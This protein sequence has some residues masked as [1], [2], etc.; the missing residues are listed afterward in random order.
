LAMWFHRVYEATQS[1]RGYIMRS[2][3]IL[4]HFMK[5]SV[6][7]KRIL[8]AHLEV[9]GRCN[10][11]CSFCLRPPKAIPASE[12]TIGE[13]E[14]ILG[15]LRALRCLNLSLTG[16]EPL[17]RTDFEDIACSSIRHGFAVSVSTNAHLL[18]E[19]RVR[20]WASSLPFE[21]I[22]ISV[23]SVDDALYQSIFG[24]HV[25]VERV[26][27]NIIRL[28]E[29]GHTV[30]VNCVI[31]NRNIKEA[32]AVKEFFTTRGFA[33]NDIGFDP[34]FP[35]MN[36]PG[37]SDQLSDYDSLRD[38]YLRFPEEIDRATSHAKRGLTCVAGRAMML[39]L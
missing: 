34:V 5:K 39:L 26:F 16:G 20:K 4:R 9:T 15:Q 30:R 8:L 19:D 29:L 7:S 11:H 32:P 1:L 33:G 38:L 37:I 24:V 13:I 2:S 18:T 21:S 17:L 3:E 35:G 28:K 14:D 25:D 23:H 12:F 36:A 31:T 10:A 27:S 6:E 22:L